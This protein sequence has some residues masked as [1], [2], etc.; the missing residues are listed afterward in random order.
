MTWTHMW[1]CFVLFSK[2]YKIIFTNEFTIKVKINIVNRNAVNYIVITVKLNLSTLNNG[3][4][5]FQTVK[6]EWVMLKSSGWKLVNI[7]LKFMHYVVEIWGQKA[8]S[9]LAVWPN[10]FFIQCEFPNI[11]NNVSLSLCTN[12]IIK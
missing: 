8:N 12:L 3:G 10:T 11:Y 1:N 4:F 2:G 7:Y 9:V 6:W 5:L